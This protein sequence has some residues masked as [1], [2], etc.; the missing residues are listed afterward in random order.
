MAG[1]PNDVSGCVGATN[2]LVLDGDAADLIHPGY[3]RL[4]GGT[5][6][7]D[8]APYQSALSFHV[9]SLAGKTPSYLWSAE[10]TSGQRTQALVVG[11]YANASRPAFTPA[12]T[13]GLAI[14][15][16]YGC[17]NRGGAFW[18]HEIDWSGDFLKH[19]LLAFEQRCEGQTAVLRG[20][21][22]YTAP[23]AY[24]DAGAGP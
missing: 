10:M 22:N 15:G 16:K 9:Q 24:P 13:P 5:W 7:S 23:G 11:T 21:I 20:C 1:P 3:E 12:G 14:S 8:P 2:V 19:V 18:I 17:D 6:Q 4:E